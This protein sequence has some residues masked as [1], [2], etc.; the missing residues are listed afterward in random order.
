MHYGQAAGLFGV[1]MALM[2]VVV[3]RTSILSEDP[4]ELGMGEEQR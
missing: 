2:Y 1:F 4:E 3:R